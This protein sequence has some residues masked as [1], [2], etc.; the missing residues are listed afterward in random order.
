VEVRSWVW[1][2]IPEAIKGRRHGGDDGGFLGRTQRLKMAKVLQEISKRMGVDESTAASVMRKSPDL[3]AAAAKKSKV[4]DSG[5][6]VKPHGHHNAQSSS[7]AVVECNE[8]IDQT[9]Y[10]GGYGKPFGG[11]ETS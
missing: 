3:Y 11:S 1:A 5:M 7:W 6:H 2:Y 9:I 10:I 4:A 8:N